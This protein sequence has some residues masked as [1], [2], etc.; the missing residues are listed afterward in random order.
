MNQ[1][2]FQSRLSTT[3]LRSERLRIRIVVGLTFVAFVVRT[4]RTTVVYNREKATLGDYERGY[5]SFC[6]L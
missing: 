5:C 6:L 3:L 4:V 1:L 2:H